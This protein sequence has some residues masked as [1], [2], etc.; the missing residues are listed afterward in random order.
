MYV[1]AFAGNSVPT[2]SNGDVMLNV[3]A[4]RSYNSLVILRVNQD[5]DDPVTFTLAASDLG[6]SLSNTGVSL[7]HL[8]IN[9]TKLNADLGHDP[10]TFYT[11]GL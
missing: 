11:R 3:E 5:D 6:V 4:G 1:G 7:F 10:T 2:I 9:R 8:Q